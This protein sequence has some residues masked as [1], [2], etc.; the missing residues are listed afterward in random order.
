MH[1]CIATVPKHAMQTGSAD[2]VL[3]LC[4]CCH[5]LTAVT[6]TDTVLTLC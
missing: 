2:T 6:V 4:H 5:C 1:P 3:T